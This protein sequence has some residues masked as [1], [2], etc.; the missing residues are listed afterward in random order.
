MAKTRKTRRRGR[1]RKSNGIGKAGLTYN[2]AKGISVE[3]VS[4]SIAPK[5]YDFVRTCNLAKWSSSNVADT[6]YAQ[7]FKLDDLPAV[8][9]FTSLFDYYRICKVE[10][11]FHPD[12]QMSNQLI[13]S[14]AA[15]AHQVPEL[16]VFRDLDGLGS[17]TTIDQAHQRQD[18][19]EKQ[20]TQR[21]SM[22]LVPQVSRE[23]YRGIT[24]TAY[25]IPQKLTW[26]DLTYTD[27]P[28]F[29]VRGVMASTNAST[30]NVQFRYNI[31]ARYWIQL[32]GVR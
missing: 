7:S 1:K 5:V 4:R 11:T 16:Y 14:T 3:R 9:D 15:N 24:T 2:Q 21:F 20:A 22:S 27:I 31:T 26:L 28:H 6:P 13:G 30:N 12:I 32:K 8:A 10:L 23:V 19:M 18:V 17:G 25:E 29:G